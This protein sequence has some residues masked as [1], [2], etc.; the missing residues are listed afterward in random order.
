[1][2]LVWQS[3][4][5]ARLLLAGSGLPASDGCD[6]DIRRALA[7]LSQ[8]E[9]ARVTFKT[10]FDDAEKASII[11]AL[12]VL[13][14]PSLA[15]SFGIAYLE[16]WMCRKAVIGSRIGSTEC[17]IQDGVD[18]V[19]VTPEDPEDLAGSILQLI[20]DRR[21]RERMGNAGYTKTLASFTWA[22][23]A[24]Q[25]EVIYENAR[26]N[27]KQSRRLPAAVA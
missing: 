25:V 5:N 17:V 1:M 15:E 20:A 3:N 11:D 14:M 22:K 21:T 8:A 24:D 10:R 27:R 16:A 18:G 26:A 2:K 7:G 4:P 9:R 6:D 12:D 23:V 19:L 13:A